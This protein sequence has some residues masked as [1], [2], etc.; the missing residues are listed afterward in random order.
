MAKYAVMARDSGAKMI[1]GCCGTT[2]EHLLS[3]RAA[4]ESE[5]R[6]SSVVAT[7]RIRD[8]SLFRGP[9]RKEIE[10]RTSKRRRR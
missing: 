3:M 5:V 10:E 7:S 8:W 9:I 6:T 2:S 4:L 1:G